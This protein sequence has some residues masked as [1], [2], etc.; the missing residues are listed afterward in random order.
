MIVQDR[1]YRA[2]AATAAANVL[3]RP[4]N[5]LLSMAAV[6]LAVRSIGQEAY[7]VMVMC[8]T[9]TTW[10]GSLDCG[11]SSSSINRVVAAR[12][13]EGDVGVRR[14]VSTAFYFLLGVGLVAAASVC[15]AACYTGLPAFL[16]RGDVLP[17]WQVQACMVA[18][19]FYA[20]FLFPL[21]IFE[22][23][24]V[25]FQEG[26]LTVTGQV[27]GNLAGLALLAVAVITAAN[28]PKAAW[29][30]VGG[31]V[32]GLV[33]IAI[34]ALARHGKTFVPAWRFASATELS[35]LLSAGSW[36]ILIGLAGQ[37][38]LQSD[39]LI[40]GMASNAFGAGNG[41]AVAADLA[42][43]MRLFNLINA[44]AILAINPLWPAY[45]EA[46]AKGDTAWL[47]KT[48]W[49]STLIAGAVSLAAVV[50]CVMFGH[51]ILRLWVGESVTVS[52]SL[53]IAC[54]AW[55]VMMTIGQSLNVFLNGLGFL[56]Y[57]FGLNLLFLCL[58]LPAK[59]LGLMHFGATGLVAVTAAVFAITQVVPYFL[60]IRY[61][62][63]NRLMDGRA[64]GTRAVTA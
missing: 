53:L 41:A 13:G 61:R 29:A 34:A 37:V 10:L 47:L 44:F 32:I 43:P 24:S 21:Q 27:L 18:F 58:V 56:K 54:A 55:T 38:G 6:A 23:A 39:P 52:T 28:L 59:V 5:M 7:G 49:R 40:A 63:L 45:A 2:A 42:I 51:H 16:N 9:A 19:G 48:L 64:T 4:I 17:G 8:I 33:L 46:A 36:F 12:T 22:R 57:Q 20:L 25:G 50:P 60:L 26:W 30:W 15:G 62:V 14:V 1:R 31:T 3:C 11:L 35:A